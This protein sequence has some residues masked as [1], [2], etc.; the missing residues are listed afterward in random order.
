MKMKK[1][2][3]IVL[4][5]SVAMFALPVKAQGFGSSQPIFGEQTYSQPAF[6]STSTLASSGSA[7]SATP[8]AL[9]AHGV[10][11]Y[12]E[13]TSIP[14]S[15]RHLRRDVNP[16]VNPD[17]DKD[18]PIGDAVWPLMLMAIGYVVWKRRRRIQ[19]HKMPG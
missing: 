1:S 8:A 7:Y 4:V 10:A 11:S 5:M 18:T 14:Q 6:R 2:T 15:G 19:R 16:V 3:I 12:G 9:N 17:G 13:G